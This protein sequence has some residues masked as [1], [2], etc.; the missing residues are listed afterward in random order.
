MPHSLHI[1]Y[2]AEVK[3]SKHHGSRARSAGCLKHKTTARSSC[4][5]G[6]LNLSCSICLNLF[7][8][9]MTAPVG[10]N[11]ICPFFIRRLQ[12]VLIFYKDAPLGF[13]SQEKKKMLAEGLPARVYE[14]FSPCKNVKHLNQ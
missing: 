1:Q 8:S 9:F 14:S 13:T 12:Q 4:S 2:K 5:I 7:S 3:A 10:E 11:I 6:N